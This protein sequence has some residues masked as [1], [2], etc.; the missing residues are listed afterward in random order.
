MKKFIF[1]L[2]FLFMFCSQAFGAWTIAVTKLEETDHYLKWQALCTSDGSTLTATDLMVASSSAEAVVTIER[3]LKGKISGATLMV[4]RAVSGTGGVV[5]NGTYT[6]TLNNDENNAIFTSGNFPV[7]YD[8]A[9]S[10]AS[11]AEDMGQYPTAFDK[12]YAVISDI[13]DSG[14]QVTLIFECWKESD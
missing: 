3:N 7:V 13:G 12:L 14:D 4:L 5:P 11:L 10:H 9:N 8:V 6:V 1:A 2:I